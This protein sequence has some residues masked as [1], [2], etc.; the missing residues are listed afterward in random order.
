[1]TRRLL[2]A[3]VFVLLLV[4]LGGCAPSRLRCV[5]THTMAPGVSQVT[6]A[7]EAGH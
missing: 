6:L 4:L 3:G 7:C 1:M 5:S 2:S